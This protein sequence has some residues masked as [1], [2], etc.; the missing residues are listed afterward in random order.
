MRRLI[1][2]A[3][4]VLLLV[5]SLGVAPPD[6]LAPLGGHWRCSVT[7]GRPAERSYFLVT[8]KL[9]P[10]AER[11]EVFG[12]QDT[13]EPDGAPSTSFERITENAGG[14]VTIWAVEGMGTAGNGAPPLRFAGRTFDGEA[15]MEISYTVTGDAMRRTA[16]RGSATVDD[17]I[18]A[19]EPESL[20]VAPCAR[21]DIHATTVRVI[22]PFTPVEAYVAKVKGLVQVRIVLDDRSRVLWADVVRSASPLLDSTAIQAARGSTYQTAI[23]NC[24]AIPSEYIFSVDFE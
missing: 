20:P 15:T 19:R 5:A 22:E 21:P 10:N 24:R 9:G 6:S 11:R 7:G 2:F 12:R 16:K 4:V 17:E 8:D 23:V 18:C 1:G 3:A 13:T 14:G